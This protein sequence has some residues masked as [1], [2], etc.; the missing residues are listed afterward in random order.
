MPNQWIPAGLFGLIIGAA[1]TPATIPLALRLGLVD[2]P[3]GRKQHAAA[4]PL[5]GG[6]ALYLTVV[7]AVR[8]FD[9]GRGAGLLAAVSAAFGVGLFDDWAKTHG[10]ELGPLPKLLMQLLPTLLFLAAGRRIFYLSNP[11]G[12]LLVLPLPL[13]YV[14]TALWLLG[15]TNTVNFIDGMD[16]LAAGI[17]AVGALTLL[18][19]AL[20]MGNPTAAVWLSALLGA[21][22]GFL[23]FNRPPARLFMG[24]SGSN[25]L[26]FTMAALSVEGYFKTA[27]VMGLIVPVFALAVPVLNGLFVVLWRLASGRR[28]YEARSDHSFNQLHR[29]GLGQWQTVV[30]FVLLAA[31]LS[32][33]GLALAFRA[34]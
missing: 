10:R 22:L 3:G 16:G 34:H 17:V 6:L 29:A 27:T 4:T 19:V 15:I 32:A 28:I 33:S 26:G 11:F 21:C 30:V 2:R 25:F 12:T 8:L 13:D 14:L 9:P 23:R 18:V 31:A 20:R 7:T 5:L 24:D 1:L